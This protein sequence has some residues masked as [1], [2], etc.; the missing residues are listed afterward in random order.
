M[1]DV[2]VGM[3]HAPG[4]GIGGEV[5]KHV[6]VDELLQVEPQAVAPG[7]DYDIGAYAGRAGN[8]AAGVGDTYVVRVVAGRD[9]DL[10]ACGL[11]ETR[12]GFRRERGK[13]TRGKEAADKAS[14]V[15]EKQLSGNGNKGE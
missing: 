12:A 4:V 5:A 3:R 7:T 8:I 6:F 15:H 11:G 10:V 1:V 2:A 9:A 14:A 13:Q